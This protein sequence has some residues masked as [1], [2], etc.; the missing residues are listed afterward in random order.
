MKLCEDCTH[1]LPNNLWDVNTVYAREMA[2]CQRTA[3]V[4]RGSGD[5]CEAERSRFFGCG[6]WGLFFKRKP[7]ES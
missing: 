1:F 4:V 2:V 3:K 7:N 6:P 5:R